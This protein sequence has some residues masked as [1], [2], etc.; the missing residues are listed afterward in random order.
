MAPTVK[1]E[2]CLGRNCP[3]LLRRSIEP[4]RIRNS[5]AIGGLSSGGWGGVN[6]G[7]HHL[8]QFNVFFSQIGY[9][10]DKSGPQNSPTLFV[11][12]LSADKL[13]RLH[14]YADAG[15]DDVMDS[16][17]LTSSQQFHGVLDRLHVDNVFYA[18]P[19]GH[20][21]SGPDYG[22]NYD[23]KHASDSLGFVG[24]KFQAALTQPH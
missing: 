7:L 9:F 22:W 2:L 4:G 11:Q 5:G 23:H 1:W 19:G 20:G 15:K 17:F 10:I 18:F 21:L 16:S 13:K 6:I 24:K 14:I 12:T 3:R 8:D